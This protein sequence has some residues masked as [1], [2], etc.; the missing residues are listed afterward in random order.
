MEWKGTTGN[1][2]HHSRPNPERSNRPYRILLV[3]EAV[4]LGYGTSLDE[5]A[6]IRV[7]SW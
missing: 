1:T 7:E 4:S 5:A 6:E 3:D 2:D